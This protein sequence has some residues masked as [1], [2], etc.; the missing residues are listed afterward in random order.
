MMKYQLLILQI[1]S[2]KFIAIHSSGVCVCSETQ[3]QQN[4]YFLLQ[5]YLSHTFIGESYVSVSFI[6]YKGYIH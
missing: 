5:N 1:M 3:V 6:F 2:L 4:W